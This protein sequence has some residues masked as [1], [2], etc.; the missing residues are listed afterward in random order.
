MSIDKSAWGEGPWQNELDEVS[1]VDD[2]TGYQC[3]ASRHPELGHLCGYVGVDA[4]HPAYGRSYHGYEQVSMDKN[5]EKF[6]RQAG[7][8][9]PLKDIKFPTDPK[10]DSLAKK[11]RNIRVHGGLTYSGLGK[12]G[13]HLFGFD[14][15]QWS[16]IAPGMDALVKKSG[17]ES[18]P[19]DGATYKDLNFVKAECTQLAK[20]LKALA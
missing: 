2:G 10:L 11:I 13:L 6:D 18:F 1:W 7:K 4:F 19:R 16:D 20:Q 12:D 14:C 17:G 5:I 9:M 8:G 15:I 3:I